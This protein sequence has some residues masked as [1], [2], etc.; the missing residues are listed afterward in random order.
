[1]V[2]LYTRIPQQTSTANPLKTILWNWKL[3]CAPFL[4]HSDITT[5]T[6]FGL[7]FLSVDNN[8]KYQR[9]GGQEEE[10]PQLKTCE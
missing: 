3:Q 1:M 2:D 9:G 7:H 4:T 8:K 10:Q 5:M 6:L